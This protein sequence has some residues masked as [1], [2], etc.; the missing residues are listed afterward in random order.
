[1]ADNFSKGEEA[2]IKEIAREVMP[3]EQEKCSA[4]RIFSKEKNVDRLFEGFSK[5]NELVIEL[6]E[7]KKSHDK[8]ESD[9]TKLKKG[10]WLHKGYSFIGSGIG[11]FFAMWLK[12]KIEG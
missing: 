5:I 10:R 1:M 3:D 2:Q 8:V 12:K 11:A 4:Y 9:I 6:K 7:H